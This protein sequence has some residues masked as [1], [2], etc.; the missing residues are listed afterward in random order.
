MNPGK[1][2][3]TNLQVEDIQAALHPEPF[4]PEHPAIDFG[5]QF[6]AD[7]KF[8]SA[9]VLIP[10]IRTEASWDILFTRRTDLVQ[11]HKGQV[12]FPGG[13]EE[14]VDAGPAD[15]ALREAWEEIGLVPGQVK[16]L[17]YLEPMISRGGYRI[18]PVVGV[19]DWPFELKL[20]E[21]EVSQVFTIPLDW[22]AETTHFTERRMSDG[23]TMRNVPVIFYQPFDGE[24]LWGI[25]ARITLTLIERL[26]ERH[27]IG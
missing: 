5:L 10:F 23:E 6:P 19:I 17:G 21:S 8:R 15:T 1:S 12:A 4:S 20:S 26:I 9:A 22:L 24:L 11:D 25:S 7:L 27:S 14:A 18:T 3:L 2:S 16:I 13:A